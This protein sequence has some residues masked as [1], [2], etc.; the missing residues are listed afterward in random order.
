MISDIGNA[1]VRSPYPFLLGHILS[2]HQEK[3]THTTVRISLCCAEHASAWLAG[4]GV[5]GG[6]C[7]GGALGGG[8]AGQLQA[9]LVGEHRAAAMGSTH[10]LPRAFPPWSVASRSSCRRS[11]I[12]ATAM[13]DNFRRL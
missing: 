9:A 10:G 2:F 1:T 4:A 6:A 8:V 13:A 11:S 3:I 5:C 7:G 12:R